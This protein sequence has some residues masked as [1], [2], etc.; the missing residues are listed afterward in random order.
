MHKPRHSVH[1]RRRELAVCWGLVAL[2]VSVGVLL[3][4]ILGNPAVGLVFAILAGWPLT[5]YE[6][7]PTRPRHAYRH[8]A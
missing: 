4:A 3:Q 8:P 1:Y 2:I 5:Q 7:V 6:P